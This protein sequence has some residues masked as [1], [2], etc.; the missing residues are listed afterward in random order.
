MFTDLV[1][2]T[3]KGCKTNSEK[4]EVYAKVLMDLIA[5]GSQATGFFLWPL[6]HPEKQINTL[7]IPITV[8]CISCGYWENYTTKHTLFGKL[9]YF[10]I[11][12]YNFKI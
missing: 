5:V 4:S 3:T 11:S 6:L 2:R 10:E 7:V 12:N 9:Y 8:F 1:S